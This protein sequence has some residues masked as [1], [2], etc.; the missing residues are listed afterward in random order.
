MGIDSINNPT[1]STK[2]VNFIAKSFVPI[3]RIKSLVSMT[4]L[5][6]IRRETQALLM[7][8]S[9]MGTISS[10]I[11]PSFVEFHMGIEGF[12]ALLLPCLAPQ[13]VSSSTSVVSNFGMVTMTN[14]IRLQGGI[15]LTNGG[16]RAF[17]P[18]YGM[19]YS[20]WI[21]IEKFGPIKDNIHPIRLLSVIRHT[22][23]REDYRY[24]LQVYIH[25]KDKSLLVSTQEHSYQS[26]C[27]LLFSF[28]L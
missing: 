27:H 17:P 10:I 18:Q 23:N 16:E 28:F 12:G 25:S 14:D 19:T 9:A 3:N 7:P 5:R 24:I 11:Y 15:T 21:S 8:H 1:L 6:D 4:T 13:S 2:D 20:T 26:K 22:F